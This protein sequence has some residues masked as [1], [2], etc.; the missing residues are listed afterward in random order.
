MMIMSTHRS[1]EST[2]I[3]SARL[4]AIALLLVSAQP[5]MAVPADNFI[6]NIEAKCHV[7]QPLARD[8]VVS[9]GIRWYVIGQQHD[10]GSVVCIR[11]SIR[12]GLAAGLHFAV[13]G[14]CYSAC[15]MTQ[16]DPKMCFGPNASMHYHKAS[17]GNTYQIGGYGTLIMFG[18]LRQNVKNWINARGGLPDPGQGYLSMYQDDLTQFFPRCNFL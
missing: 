3:K 17:V 18:S 16:I 14:P 11:K 4:A 15:T 1:Q 12:Q 10:G 9:G 5:T 6:A 13:N 7:Y 2:M 8:I